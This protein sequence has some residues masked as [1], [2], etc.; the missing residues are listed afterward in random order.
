[1][2]CIAFQYVRERQRCSFQS[3]TQSDTWCDPALGPTVPT[4]TTT[5]TPPETL[6]EPISGLHLHGGVRLEAISPYYR[7]HVGHHACITTGPARA[8]VPQSHHSPTKHTNRRRGAVTEGS[9]LIDSQEFLS[10]L[11]SMSSY[12]GSGSGS[13]STR[14]RL[15]L[16]G[17]SRSMKAHRRVSYGA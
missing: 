16:L 8:Q 11:E 10:V 14:A 9:V 4:Q 3:Y 17:K 15:S 6:P 2:P 1:M 5:P 7:P 13:G 12:I